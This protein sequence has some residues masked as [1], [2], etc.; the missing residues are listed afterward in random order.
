MRCPS[1]DSSNRSQ[2]SLKH[3][4]IVA[5]LLAIAAMATTPR[6]ASAQFP[7]AA[8]TEVLE[9]TRVAAFRQQIERA[10]ECVKREDYEC[11]LSYYKQAYATNPQPLILFNMA[12][13][14]RKADRTKDALSY[15]ERFL[16]ESPRSDLTSE[17]R[18][19]V[20]ALRASNEKPAVTAWPPQ[21]PR[22]NSADHFK[23]TEPERLAR[24]KQHLQ[25]A[26]AKASTGDCDGAVTA[27]WAAYTL[28]PKTSLIFNVAR[29][30]RNAGRLAE[31]LAL[32]QRYLQEEPD[33]SAGPEV[34][35][36]IAEV[37]QQLEVQQREAAERLAKAN[38]VL[39]ERLAEV[40]RQRSLLS[41]PNKQL[42]I[43]RRAWFWGV[44]GTAAAGIALGAGLGIGLQPKI[45]DADLGA[46][47]LKF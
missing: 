24:Y 40:E 37:K 16:S 32:Y 23:G 35:G 22:T 38:A 39:A 14:C 30:Y 28:K 2:H 36:Y 46:R 44:V 9:A 29:V 42:P 17:V 4:R 6:V 34:E 43:Y 11:A 12:Q 31:A 5:I 26:V 8:G 1:L 19:Y 21:S 7:Q 47:P 27:Y 25:T 41:L 33:S 15:F 18:N 45:P 10:S 20:T 3:A 13:V